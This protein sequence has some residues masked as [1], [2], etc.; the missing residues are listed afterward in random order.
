MNLDI[1]GCVSTM[2]KQQV[3]FLDLD[4]G[5]EPVKTLLREA[6]MDEDAC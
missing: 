3:L 6:T 5:I 4:M 2:P 1:G